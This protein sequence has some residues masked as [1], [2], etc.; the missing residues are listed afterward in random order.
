METLRLKNCVKHYNLFQFQ[1]DNPYR[2]FIDR[3]NRKTAKI[4]FI[5]IMQEG[6]LK[7]INEADKL[8]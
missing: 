7:K 4:K 6:L 5:T 2:I 1:I 3:V 8:R